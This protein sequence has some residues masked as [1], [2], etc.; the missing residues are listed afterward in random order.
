MWL[1]FRGNVF[2]AGLRPVWV[3]LVVLAAGPGLVILSGCGIFGGGDSQPALLP[4]VEPEPEPFELVLIGVDRLNSCGEP[5][6]YALAVRVYQLGGDGQ[7]ALTS[8]VDL[9][10]NEQSELGDD[11]VDRERE[12]LLEPGD[13][14]SVSIDLRPDARFLA[15]VG[16]FCES[17][18]ECWRWH[19]PIGDLGPRQSLTFTES[20]IQET[21]P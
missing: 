4:E 1:L 14:L 17:N 21:R 8:L 12:L 6:G 16:Y 5:R 7:I 19:R 11:I 2:E 15:V 18:G 3:F 10:K 20:C 13:T 9:W